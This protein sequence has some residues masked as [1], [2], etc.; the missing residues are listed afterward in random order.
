M[1]S[2]LFEQIRQN[3]LVGNI[4]NA[5]IELLEIARDTRYHNEIILHA[6]A[7]KAINDE[8][9]IGIL[10]ST[11]IRQEKNRIAKSILDLATELEKEDNSLINRHKNKEPIPNEGRNQAFLNYAKVDVNK[12]ERLFFDLKKVGLKI[13]FDKDF[14]L[15]G[16]K[17]KI[18]IKKVIKNCRYFLLLFSSNSVNHRGFVN[19]EITYALDLLDEF[20]ETEIFI[21][22][23]RIDKCDPSHEKLHDLHWVDMFPNWRNGINKILLATEIIENNGLTQRSSGFSGSPLRS[24]PENR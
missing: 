2:I 12:A 24:D 13:W 17:W 11:E 20:P 1:S 15:P 21:I 7:L 22:P 19:K 8:Q 14:L 9:R 4:Q 6:S 23:I 16:Q 18:E 3:I 10:N 5:I